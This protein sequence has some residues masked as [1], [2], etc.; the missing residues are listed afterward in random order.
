MCSLASQRPAELEIG[1]T[2]TRRHASNV[3]S[4]LVS[5]RNGLQRADEAGDRNHDEDDDFL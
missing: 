5:P 3:A 1:S 2:L 4:S